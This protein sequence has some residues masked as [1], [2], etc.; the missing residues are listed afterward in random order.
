MLQQY[1]NEYMGRLVFLVLSMVVYEQGL[2]QTL[3]KTVDSQGRTSF[4]DKP[5]SRDSQP[6]SVQV[7]APN[8]DDA[9][10]LQREQ[11]ESAAYAERLRSRQLTE[12]QKAAE[13]AEQQRQQKNFC[14]EARYRYKVLSEGGRIVE[15]GGKGERNYLSSEDIVAGREEARSVVEEYCNE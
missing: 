1:M 2:A 5:V 10:R 3:Y 6:T 14:N 9:A 8:S 12:Q 11:A 4:S 15:V 7:S 13:K